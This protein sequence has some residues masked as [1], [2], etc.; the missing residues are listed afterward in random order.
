MKKVVVIM[1]FLTLYQIQAQESKSAIG[2]QGGYVMPGNDSGD[3]SNNGFAGELNF[4][5]SLSRHLSVV[6]SS[7]Y[8][9]MTA[10]N[11][12]EAWRKL[13]LNVGPSFRIMDKKIHADVFGL[14]GYAMQKSP[15]MNANYPDSSVLIRKMPAMDMNALQGTLGIKFGYAISKRINLY[16]KPQ[17]TT[18]FSDFSYQSRD[19]SPAINERGGI[20]V[21]AANSIPFENQNFRSSNT[22]VNVGIDISFANDW[23]STRSN[24]TSKTS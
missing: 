18:G 20:D 13:S 24:K 9:R 22:S 8:E 11:S 7:N 2:I 12:N 4:R 6:L 15:D 21:E 14:I 10:I 23:N 5:R 17:F 19:I 3:F 1:F 16:V